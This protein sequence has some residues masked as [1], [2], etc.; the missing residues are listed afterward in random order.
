MGEGGY[1]LE[2]GRYGSASSRGKKA[3]KRGASSS[4]QHT[5][6]FLSGAARSG[7]FVGISQ[8]RGRK[9]LRGVT[10]ASVSGGTA[11]EPEPTI[12]LGAGCA[13]ITSQRCQPEACS[14]RAA[15]AALLLGHLNTPAP[16]G[17]GKELLMLVPGQESH[18]WVCREGTSPP[19]LWDD[20]PS[21]NKT[22]GR[23]HQ[24]CP[25]RTPGAR[26]GDAR[27]AAPDPRRGMP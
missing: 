19:A 5:K 13:L 16:V 9:G 25:G 4:S 27:S 12:S 15:E 6:R 3:R 20:A 8:P 22:P 26:G 14:G 21:T 17:V 2:H 18:G 11:T 7:M 23:V 1:S 24:E 10:T